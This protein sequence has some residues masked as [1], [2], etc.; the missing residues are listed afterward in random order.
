MSQ[1]TKNCSNIFEGPLE[2]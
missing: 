1:A 2:F